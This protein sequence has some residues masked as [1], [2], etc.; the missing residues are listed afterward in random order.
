MRASAYRTASLTS[1]S[2]M[3]TPAEQPSAANAQCTYSYDELRNMPL[4]PCTTE[5]YHALREKL[6][7]GDQLRPEPC[8]ATA[9]QLAAEFLEAGKPEM[10]L[11]MA[12][13]YHPLRLAAMN[14]WY[15]DPAMNVLFDWL[16][17][18]DPRC[19][20]ALDL[21]LE[22]N[23][24]KEVSTRLF[25]LVAANAPL[26]ELSLTTPGAISKSEMLQCARAL[27]N[28]DR[29]KMLSLPAG[30]FDNEV[31]SEFGNALGRNS[32]LTELHITPWD[33]NDHTNF[34]PLATGL[35]NNHSLHTLCFFS[36]EV[37]QAMFD[38]L[39]STT[40]PGL[41]NLA[42]ANCRFEEKS[43]PAMAQYL[44]KTES[45]VRLTLIGSEFDEA[46]MSNLLAGLNDN[47]S[48][49]SLD[50]SNTNI[51][52]RNIET[53][54]ANLRVNTNLR[55][56]N[57][58]RNCIEEEGAV[59]LATS[60]S[61]NTHLKKLGLRWA[62]ISPW[63]MQALAQMLC[64]NASLREVDLCGNRPDDAATETLA[65]ALK[66]NPGLRNLNVRAEGHVFRGKESHQMLSEAAMQSKTLIKC[67]GLEFSDP[68]A[69]KRHFA[70][71][72]ARRDR[73]AAIA[74]SLGQ[75]PLP[76]E[77]GAQV[78]DVLDK[79]DATGQATTDALSIFTQQMLGLEDKPK[80][81]QSTIA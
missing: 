53:L 22:H 73:L 60:L 59:V 25:D 56:L 42:F 48:L 79:L 28:N 24:D 77:V 69:A 15:K 11:W 41:R 9:G 45:L 76:V 49:Q 44:G 75:D 17:T 80:P 14:C 63:G 36:T 58:S 30:H 71:N 35:R 40:Q 61:E 29:L 33:I 55:E 65:R 64:V 6:Y 81:S 72:K 31:V 54:A 68:E 62:D 32:S 43:G 39:A 57:L 12:A 8:Q 46:A 21:Q 23:S 4:P 37:P 3:T 38:A 34:V 51:S 50:L 20:I 19:E 13:H 2:S 52:P 10:L 70:D 74:F 66:D 26:T 16:R 18:A 27:T 1:P 47:L 67:E 7:D 78:V 5:E